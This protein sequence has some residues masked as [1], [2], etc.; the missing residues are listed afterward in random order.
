MSKLEWYKI[1]VKSSLRLVPLIVNFPT[2]RFLHY[3]PAF[4]LVTDGELLVLGKHTHTL[5]THFLF[6]IL[7]KGNQSSRSLALWSRLHRS[8]WNFLSAPK[9][10]LHVDPLVLVVKFAFNGIAVELLRLATMGGQL[11][12]NAL[13]WSEY[14]PTHVCVSLREEREALCIY[15]AY[16]PTG[17]QRGVAAGVFHCSGT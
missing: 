17:L 8:C 15:G 13:D 7:M 1:S 14:C 12:C 2:V 6:C 16:M 11:P 10:A 3:K 5:G 4:C 9:S